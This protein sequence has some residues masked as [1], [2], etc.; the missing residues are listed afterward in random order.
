MVT[1]KLI[2][3][4]GNESVGPERREGSRD[5]VVQGVV[6]LREPSLLLKWWGEG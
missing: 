2:R 4:V 1:H 5:E 6:T 3:K